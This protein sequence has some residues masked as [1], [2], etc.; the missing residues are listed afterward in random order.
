MWI[1]QEIQNSLVATVLSFMSMTR[2]TNHIVAKR[3]QSLHIPLMRCK[4]DS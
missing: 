1:V 3:S 4:F 2:H